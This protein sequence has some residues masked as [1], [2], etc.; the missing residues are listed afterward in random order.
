MGDRAQLLRHCEAVL[1]E[2][3][4]GSGNCQVQSIAEIGS[5]K[6]N[7]KGKSEARLV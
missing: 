3:T 4:L 7:G 6:R 1:F 2:A 5:G